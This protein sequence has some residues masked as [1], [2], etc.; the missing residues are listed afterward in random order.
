MICHRHDIGG[1]FE[2]VM[3]LNVKTHVDSLFIHVAQMVD[4]R[5]SPH[6][7]LGGVSNGGVHAVRLWVDHE[8]LQVHARKTEFAV[9]DLRRHCLRSRHLQ[10]LIRPVLLEIGGVMED[11]AA[12]A[13]GLD[14]SQKGKRLKEAGWGKVAGKGVLQARHVRWG[15]CGDPRRTAR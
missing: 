11:V 2:L 14:L 7:D 15:C 12:S 10:R 5:C 9:V 1:L 6:A 8:A 4:Y 3:P 13:G